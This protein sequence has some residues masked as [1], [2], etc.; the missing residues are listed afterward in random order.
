MGQEKPMLTKA[1]SIHFS[2]K[3]KRDSVIRAAVTARPRLV[4]KGNAIETNAAWG[5]PTAT[6]GAPQARLLLIVVILIWGANWPVM[7][8]GVSLVPPLWFVVARL[9][10]GLLSL[11]LP[12]V[13]T[14]RLRLPPRHD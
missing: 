9:V 7:R 6:V 2:I 1:S 11:A 4:L 3:G 12:L 14:G 5:K 8:V 10:L 13:L